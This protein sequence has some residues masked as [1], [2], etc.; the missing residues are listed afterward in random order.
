VI[1]SVDSHDNFITTY[2]GTTLTSYLDS[3]SNGLFF[4]DS[5]IPTCTG[6][7]TWAYCPASTISLTATN[8]AATGS[9]S[10]QV[11]QPTP[12]IVHANNLFTNTNII[13]AGNIG[14]PGSASTFAWGLPFFYGRTVYTAISGVS[15]SGV[16]IGP[17]WAY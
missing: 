4:N 8:T 5:S 2:N 12:T 9:P 11:S 16:P 1:Y 15:V 3:G 6:V 17:Y 13:V 7:N 10:H 14:G